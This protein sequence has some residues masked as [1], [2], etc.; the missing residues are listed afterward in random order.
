MFNTQAFGLKLSQLRKNADMTQSDLAERLNVTRQAVSKYETGD[1][2]PD[3]TILV[4]MAE[5]FGVSVD[6]LICAGTPTVGEAVILHSLAHG[7]ETAEGA[8][9]EDVASLAVWL[10][11]ST[12]E[13]LTVNLAKQ[14]INISRLMD[15]AVYLSDEGTQRLL[16]ETDCAGITPEMLEHLLPFMDYDSWCRILDMILNGEMDWHLIKPLRVDRSLV[17]AAVIEGVLPD[18]ALG[19]RGLP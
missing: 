10:K 12:V 8:T 1:S 6:E 5:I 19:I 7:K 4:T 18:E 14:G 9:P 15:L 17:E 13:R 16:A 3:V 2:F 11:P